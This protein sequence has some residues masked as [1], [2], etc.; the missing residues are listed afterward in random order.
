MRLL[1]A[2]HHFPP[3][4]TYGA[5]L[6]AFRTARELV[7]RGH[8]VLVVCV[9]EVRSGSGELRW[10]DETYQGIPV[11][12]LT[13]AVPS[14]PDAARWEYDNPRIEEH[15]RGLLASMQPDLLHLFSGYLLTG[16]VLQACLD[17]SV[18]SVVTPIDY[19]FLC[20]RITLL[21]ADGSVCTTPADPALCAF[22]L[23]SGRRR[24]RLPDRATAGLLGLALGRAWQLTGDCLVRAQED[25][26][27]YLRGAI[28]AA[29]VLISNSRFLLEMLAA[30]GINANAARHIRQ[31]IDTSQ[32][33]PATRP[34][35]GEQLRIGYIGQIAPHKGV[36]VLLDA[37]VRLRANGRARTP[38]L[39]VYG[40]T[41]KSPQYT[42]R[43]VRKA[44]SRRD[45]TFAGSFE[46][47]QIRRVHAGI[48][49]LVVPSVWYENSPSV[50]L[51]AYACGTPV[52]TARFGGMAELVREGVDGLL[53]TPGEAADLARV[54]QRFLDEPDLLDELRG[55]VPHV[56]TVA[57]E[58]RELEAVY[59]SAVGG[60]L[61]E[62]SSESPTAEAQRGS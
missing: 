57:E 53:A 28:K 34:P 31:G 42:R 47:T 29:S 36:D 50:I 18:P 17:E 6:Q 3:R 48:D 20:P 33:A 7:A 52:V 45:I 32:W 14:G 46:N 25:R 41:T 37:F 2:V 21:R 16:S 19:W 35:D 61:R 4:Y 24:Y 9:E 49:L 38:R 44:R 5:E 43:L 30:S 58:V 13:L 10:R 62:G 11:R 60:S 22:C 8:E 23:R 39:I 51:E 26:S 40:D 12:R 27:R 15:V 56:G 55:G 54:L 1:L 59:R